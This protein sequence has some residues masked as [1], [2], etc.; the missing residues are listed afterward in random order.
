MKLS[1]TFPNE[2][3]IMDA[4]EEYKAQTRPE[5]IK[6]IEEGKPLPPETE[7][8]NRFTGE[9]EPISS[10]ALVAA[11]RRGMFTNDPCT[12]HYSWRDIWPRLRIGA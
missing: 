2:A 4:I 9:W 3:R 7:I 12:W 1:R 5:I 6:L 10:T 8:Q 11:N